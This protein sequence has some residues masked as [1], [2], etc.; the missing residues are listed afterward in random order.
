MD[1]I[2]KK[3]SFVLLCLFHTAS[4]YAG[5]WP[6]ILGQSRNGIATGETLRD[7]W[8]KDGP[9]QEWSI[10]VGQGFAGVAVRDDVVT[11]FHR[12]ENAEVVENRSAS[13]GK[14]L[15]ATK[16]ATRY[17][18][19]MSADSGPRCVPIVTENVIIV[20]GVAGNLRCLDRNSGK[21][22]WSRDTW[23]D[24]SAPEGYFGAGSSPLVVGDKVLVNVGGRNNA[25]VVAFSIKDGKTIWQ[26]YSDTASY[27]SPV[28]AKFGSAT[29]A[30]FVT[31]LNT[32]AL[33]PE[34]GKLAF[35]F[36]F[37]E[38][39]PTV[40][41]ANPVVIN[42]K[43]FVSSSYR[44]GSVL[45]S[46]AGNKVES[47][48]SGERLLATQYAT[49]IQHGRVLFAVDGRQDEG[50]GSASLKCID[51]GTQS[52][53]WAEDGFDYGTLVGVND[54]LLFLTHTGD[55][56]R[57]DAD[58]KQYNETHRSHVLDSTDREYRL[59]AVSNGRLL[60]RDSKRLKSLSI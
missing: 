43:I 55:L 31:R 49:P 18:S 57:F 41:G 34:T 53:L 45:A 58:R 1:L 36:P 52:V 48:S 24:F 38:R 21:E 22:I 37:G 5:D 11:L 42:E 8:P 28:I 46:V 16:F 26:S 47:V 60:I 27:S 10:D 40:N 44:I 59:P 12:L 35:E 51:P 6:Q 56:I 25:A 29:R 50:P 13:D 7:V 19:G 3:F 23:K 2:M 20:F 9:K 54:E 33:D 15:W 4:L 14:Q 32:I 39:G 17:R 30:I